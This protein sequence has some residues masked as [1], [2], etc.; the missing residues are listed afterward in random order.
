[1]RTTDD[2]VGL[3]SALSWTHKSPTCMHRNT[4][5]AV[6][7]AASEEANKISVLK[8]GYQPNLILEFFYP[9]PRIL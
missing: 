5:A 3:S 7:N 2:M 6:L 8:P 1:M 4:S 9:L